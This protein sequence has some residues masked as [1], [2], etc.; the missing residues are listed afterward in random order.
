MS[1]S[2]V[3]CRRYLNAFKPQLEKAAPS[4]PTGRDS[5]K[6]K[7]IDSHLFEV[8]KTIKDV[9]TKLQALEKATQKTKR[10]SGTRKEIAQKAKKARKR[11]SKINKRSVDERARTLFSYE[12]GHQKITRG[13]QQRSI[14]HPKNRKLQALDSMAQRALKQTQ[15]LYRAFHALPKLAKAQLDL[16]QLKSVTRMGIPRQIHS[17]YIAAVTAG[18]EESKRLSEAKAD[19]TKNNIELGQREQT[20]EVENSIIERSRKR[21]GLVLDTNEFKKRLDIRATV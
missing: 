2:Q 7:T 19:Y 14:A 20:L 6:A 11:F 16:D 13:K 4:I 15:C 1:V 18:M 21:L 5:F 9:E 17:A 10:V 3:A 8:R 12:P